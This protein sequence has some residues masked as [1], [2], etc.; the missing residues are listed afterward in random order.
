MKFFLLLLILSTLAFACNNTVD[1]KQNT[2][3]ELDENPL[4][5]KWKLQVHQKQAQTNK[6]M[7]L[8]AQPTEVILSIMDG[9]YFMI[10]DT[11]VD[12]KFN[13][14]GFN[15]IQERSKGQWEL[16][17]KKLTLHH[18]DEDTSYI[19]ELEITTLNLNTLATKSKNKK[20][21]IFKTYKSY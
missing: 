1:D 4:V 2:E 11:F 7:N 6:E 18:Q 19:E 14:K 9:G 10:Y 5:K 13:F 15:R 16:D 12:P 17:G 3:N 21:V 8:K 20:S